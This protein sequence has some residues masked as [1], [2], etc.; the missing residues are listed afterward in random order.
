MADGIRDKV[1]IPGM[2]CT[3]FGE[4]WEFCAED[5]MVEAFVECLA[6]PGIEKKEIQ[7][8]LLGIH[9]DEMSTGKSAL[10][11]AVTLKLPYIPA[12]DWTIFAPRARAF[13]AAF[14]IPWQPASTISSLPWV[15]KIEGHGLRR[16]A[17]R[18][19]MGVNALMEAANMTAPGMF[20]QSATAYSAKWGI[21]MDKIKDAITHVSVKSHANGA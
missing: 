1:A 4:R 7:A 20:A 10:P 5:L 2:G 9:Y 15:W 13:R 11:A 3:R 12:R 16:V 6:D 19:R 18:Y 8:A 21:S 17:R 14:A